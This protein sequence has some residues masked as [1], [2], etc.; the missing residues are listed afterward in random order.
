MKETTR[1]TDTEGTVYEQSARS[2]YYYKSTGRTDKKGNPVMVRIGAK[3]FEAALARHKE[4]LALEAYEETTDAAPESLEIAPTSP[5]SVAEGETPEEGAEKPDTGSTGAEVRQLTISL[6]DSLTDEEWGRVKALWESKL[7]LER[8]AF[9]EDI[10]LEREGGL[11]KLADLAGS[12]WMHLNA[13]TCYL[14]AL[15]ALAK[16]QKRV[17]HKDTGLPENEKYAFRCWL[18]RL[19]FI[20]PDYKEFRKVLCENLTGSAAFRDVLN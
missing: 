7:S 9:G 6:P 14:N 13:Y 3:V 17:N 18:L 4:E 15:F 11:I 10:R 16:K 1:F 19:G 20:G 12:D 2:G 8:R 5:D